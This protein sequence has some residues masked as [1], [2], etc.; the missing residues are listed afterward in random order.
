MGQEKSFEQCL[1]ELEEVIK[2]LESKD[3]TLDE[4]VQAYQEGLILSQLCNQMFKEKE[5]LIVKK[6]EGTKEEDFSIDN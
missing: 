1:K 2:K 6:I 4:S 3:I 5:T